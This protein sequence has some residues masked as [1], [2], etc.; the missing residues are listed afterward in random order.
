MSTFPEFHKYDGLG[1]AELIRKREVT[2]LDL[3]EEV[4]SRIEAYNPTL[5]AVIYK[6]YDKAR[7]R[8]NSELPEG[9]FTGV[10]FLLKDSLDTVEGE[11]TS[12]GTKVL[13]NIMQTYDNETVRRLRA[14]GL[15]FVGKTNLPELCILPYTEPEIFGPTHNPWDLSRTPG[16]SSGGS[17]AA[18]A[19][20]M[21]PVAGGSDGGGSI[22]TPASC[23]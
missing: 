15:V 1:L 4:I 16:G 21:V 23:C 2:S 5:N 13:R 19:A 9:S 3:V 11:P 7:A 10:P 12:S 6:M 20:C 22:R 18:V 8:A 17:A 14:A